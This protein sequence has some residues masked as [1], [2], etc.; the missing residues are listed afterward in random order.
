MK[1]LCFYLKITEKQTDR[2]VTQRLGVFRLPSPASRAAVEE[3][4]HCERLN[5]SQKYEVRWWSW[6]RSSVG[7][8]LC[9]GQVTPWEKPRCRP[10]QMPASLLICHRHT[11]R[12]QPSAASSPF[13]PYGPKPVTQCSIL[14]TPRSRRLQLYRP[15]GAQGP[16]LHY[17]GSEHVALKTL[18]N[19]HKIT[20]ARQTMT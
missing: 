2:R 4:F 3:I 18:S 12:C 10:T 9:L 17:K 16:S 15:P 7:G 11:E 14:L 19:R 6:T 20:T 1:N 8:S 5:V 13:A